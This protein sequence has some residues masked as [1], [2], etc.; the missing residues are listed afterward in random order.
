MILGFEDAEGWL[1]YD[2]QCLR[3]G[4]VRA[5]SQSRKQHDD[6]IQNCLTSRT[7]RTRVYLST[8]PG[9]RAGPT[10]KL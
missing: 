8:E 1:F 3:I 4:V 10:L 6:T 7:S 5:V 2:K 9:A